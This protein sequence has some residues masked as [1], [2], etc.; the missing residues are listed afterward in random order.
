MKR[1]PDTCRGR[2]PRRRAGPGPES[3]PDRTETQIPTASQVRPEA[4]Q[5]GQIGGRSIP[6]Q[7][8]GRVAP[9]GWAPDH[10]PADGVNDALFAAAA[11]D[12]GLTELSLSRDRSPE[13]HRSR[14]EAVQPADARGAHSHEQRVEVAGRPE[15]YSRAR[16]GHVRAQFCA[17]SLAG[18]SGEH[19]DRCYAKA[20]LV[21]HMESVATFEAEA[22][23]GMDPDVKALAA[24]ALP[25][26]KSH[27]KM[28]KPIAKKYEHEKEAEEAAPP[29]DRHA[30]RAADPVIS[31]PDTGPFHHCVPL[32]SSANG[33]RPRSS[34][35]GGRP[36][37][38]F[39]ARPQSRRDPSLSL[40]WA[41]G[42]M[43]VS[44]IKA[45]GGSLAIIVSSRASSMKSSSISMGP[46]S[47][48][49]AVRSGPGGSPD[50]WPP[51]GRDGFGAWLRLVLVMGS[52][53]SWIVRS[54]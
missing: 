18:L 2:H 21:V 54:R 42:P 12:G 3:R 47:S 28:I 50:C 35:R 26:I 44:G 5:A 33:R 19:F 11:A 52:S 1:T 51:T 40:P 17:E 25:H 39:E 10:R 48:T 16:G 53:S 9:P 46:S 4:Q 13:G 37:R 41:G 23:R 7:N 31:R 14:A 36:F 38:A 6:G 29:S 8:G 34:G 27:L 32:P 30:D 24:K 45:A 43:A 49:A 20:Q 15:G 22:E